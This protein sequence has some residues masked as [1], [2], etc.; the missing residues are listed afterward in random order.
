MPSKKLVG[1]GLAERTVS[2]PEKSKPYLVEMTDFI[3]TVPWKIKTFLEEKY[4]KNGRS[5]A[6]IAEETLSSRAAVRDALI[7]FG[8]PL[9]KQGN[10]GLR[11]SQVP[12]GF[13]RSDGLLV[14]AD[15][16]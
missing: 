9:R 12:Y 8:I 7:G 15:S 1:L 2:S 10:P 3:H 5:I 11:P 14:L 4:V 16:H 13:R 6:Q